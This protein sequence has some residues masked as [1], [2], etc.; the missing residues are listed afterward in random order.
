M[1]SGPHY[2]TLN[3]G[4]CSAWC[5]FVILFC[6]VVL[7]MQWAVH[8]VEL[9][10]HPSRTVDSWTANHTEITPLPCY[11]K[12]TVPVFGIVSPVFGVQCK[13]IRS[14]VRCDVWESLKLLSVFL[15]TKPH[16]SDEIEK[17]STMWKVNSVN[18]KPHYLILQS[19]H[20]QHTAHVPSA[21]SVICSKQ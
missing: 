21:Q 5:L 19:W 12:Y 7:K 1:K 8:S 13:K 17:Q 10:V 16:S 3:T 15:E 18:G 11:M 14:S 4:S 9:V 20:L 2:K 6:D